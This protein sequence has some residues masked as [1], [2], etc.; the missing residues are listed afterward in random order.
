MAKG[1]KI[2]WNKV[3][4][5]FETTAVTLQELAEKYNVSPG[6][7]RS[8]KHREGWEKKIQLPMKA[9]VKKDTATQ[10]GKQKATKRKKKSA[11]LQKKKGKPKIETIIED[12]VI[13]NE[14]LTEKQRLFCLHYVKYW[15]AGKAAE[16]AGYE[17][18]YPNGYYEIGSRLVKKSQVK[19]E[20]ERLKKLLFSDIYLEAQAVLQKYIDIAFADITDFV[21]F[22]QKEVQVMG[23]FGPVYEGKGDDKKPVTKIVNFVD[24]KEGNEVDGTIITEVS[25]GRDGVKIKLADRIKALE[26]LEKYFDLFPDK[27]KRRIEEERLKLAREEL[28]LKSKTGSLIEEAIKHSQQQIKSLADMINKPAPNRKPG[29]IE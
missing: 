4:E 1:N 22:G 15:N 24:L 2:D 21:S 3:R 10:R 26:K 8:R 25:Q 11:T 23:P 12:A 29:D 16:K 18:S 27:F 5:E 9:A 7:V 17:C 13:E 19:K 6:T 14:D 20:I 28:A